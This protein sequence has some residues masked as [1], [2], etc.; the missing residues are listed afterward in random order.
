[1]PDVQQMRQRQR[2][3][4]DFGDF[5]LDH[6]N[7]D[8]ILKE[9]CRLVAEA[10]DAD[11]AKILEIERENDQAVVRAGVGW[12]P[13]IVGYE[14]IGLKERSSEAYAIEKIEPVITN[15]IECEERFDFPPFLL[16]HGVVALV[17]VPILLPGRRAW[18]VLQVDAREPREFDDESI[19]F[20]KTYSMVLGPVIDRFRV[21]AEREQARAGIAVREEAHSF[22]LAL[23]DAL[24]AQEGADAK[25]KVA[26]R[27]LGERLS[28]TRVL[29]AEFDEVKGIA[30]V[31]DGWLADGTPSFPSVMQLKDHEGPVLADLRAGRT[32][33][34]DDIDGLVD[35]PAFA[36]IAS[37]GVG[38]LLSVP[39]HVGGKLRVNLSVHQQDA[40]RWTDEEVAL[41]RDVAERLWAEV[42][43]ARAEA[44][45]RESEERHRLIVESVRSY[46]IFTTDRDGTITSWPAGAAAVFGWSEAEMVGKSM[47][48]TFVPEDVANGAP[49]KERQ[50]AVRDG[51][52]PN[53]RW[54]M[55]KDGTRIF[56]NG[57][58]QPLIN[59]D[60]VIRELIKIG[61]DVTEGRRVQQ[62]LAAN[63]ERLR[64]ATE[65]GRLG[66]WDWDVVSGE[67]HWS[68]EHFRM[69]GYAVD[70]VTPSYETWSARI[71]PDD[72][73][74]AEAALQQAMD[75]HEEF[76]HEFR[77][78]HPDNSVHW[79][80]GRGRFFYDDKGQAVR[81]I[82]AMIETTER[83][84]W[85]NRQQVLIA[86]LQHRTRNL[87]GVVRSVSDK[88][89]RTSVDL[90]DFRARFRD[91]LE[92]LSRVQGL[93]SRLNDHDRVAFDKL[94]ETELAAMGGATD[95]VRL[96]GPKG[97][98]L[99]S[100]TVQTLA[101]ALHELA[102]NAV[103][104]GALGQESGQ[105]IVTWRLANDEGSHEPR[106]HIDWRE[107][108]VNMRVAG[109]RPSGGGHGREL[110]EKALPYQLS[111]ETSYALEDDGVHC[112]I[113]IP[114]STTS[115]TGSDHA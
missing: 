41:V 70:E 89:A 34:I 50:T 64:S 16:E 32:V 106:L 12:Q 100:S 87:M 19:E 21:A 42:V 9:G 28:A 54:H 15:N 36:A 72:R 96:E 69:E 76:S 111:A 113:S 40:R 57:S 83:R 102:T 13:G 30:D 8:E 22:L 23:G 81:M 95:R 24:R 37:V 5:V 53:I 49:E 112:T 20:L 93:L 46:A 92:A 45:L 47:D 97:V 60:G 48:L 38:A 51:Y 61:E 99:R 43:R 109:S 68:D 80:S 26:A 1:M 98:R 11:L 82:G 67:I 10:L 66:L 7:L 27:H 104:Y 63:E 25:I 108:G 59:V 55:R 62:A 6:E 90:S 115:S 78:V 2:V 75:R 94:I 73:P 33:R 31:F 29:F 103:K 88:T 101:M 74:D 17:N 58:T 110:I 14:R 65:V 4:A 107:S 35:Q 18:G 56:I 86:E 77:V 3:L 114:V 52:A 84:E 79:L 44:A 105:L 91:R 39:L 85:E 71:H